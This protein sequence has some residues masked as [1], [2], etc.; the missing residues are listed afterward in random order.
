ML[1]ILT[2]A[3]A[4]VVALGSIAFAAPRGGRLR[5][6]EPDQVSAAAK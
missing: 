6:A 3:T 1:K 2:L 4:T 5:R